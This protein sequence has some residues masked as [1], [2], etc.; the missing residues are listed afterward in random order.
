M[1]RATVFGAV[2]LATVAC[3]QRP[4]HKPSDAMAASARILRQLDALE[5]SLATNEAE[6]V[7]YGVLVDRHSRAE[8]LACHVTNEHVVEIERLDTAFRKKLE[9][10]RKGKRI[11]VASR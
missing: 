1:G 6:N 2:M 10:K 11:T 4:A 3:A 8:Q 7:T 5:S 9:E